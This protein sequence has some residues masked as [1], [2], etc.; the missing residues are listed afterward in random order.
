[1]KHQF[2]MVNSSEADAM[3]EAPPKPLRFAQKAR[4]HDVDY[5]TPGTQWSK[6]AK[7]MA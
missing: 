5:E 4:F 7:I 1:M 6:E 3:K 2:K